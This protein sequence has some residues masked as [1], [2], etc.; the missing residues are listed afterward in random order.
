[1]RLASSKP[2]VILPIIKK[3]EDEDDVSDD[4]SGLRFAQQLL[5]DQKTSSLSQSFCP[6]VKGDELDAIDHLPLTLLS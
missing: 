5:P 6:E 4:V 2:V 3:N 1:M